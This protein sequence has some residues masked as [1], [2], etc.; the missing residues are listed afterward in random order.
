[1]SASLWGLMTLGWVTVAFTD[2]G[3]GLLATVTPAAGC[4]V[5]AFVFGAPAML[6]G[7]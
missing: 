2:V 5:T 6:V 1:M 3:V 4:G 7:D